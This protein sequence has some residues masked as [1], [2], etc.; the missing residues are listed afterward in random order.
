MAF[1]VQHL[2]RKGDPTGHCT[3]WSKAWNVSKEPYVGTDLSTLHLFALMTQQ[4]MAASPPPPPTLLCYSAGGLTL[5]QEFSIQGCGCL[6]GRCL[7]SDE[8]QD[9]QRW[10]L[11][12]LDMPSCPVLGSHCPGLKSWLSLPPTG[13]SALI[14]T[15][16]FTLSACWDLLSDPGA[17]LGEDKV[18]R[19]LPGPHGPCPLATPPSFPEVS[20]LRG[21]SKETVR[22]VNV[23]WA[24]ILHKSQCSHH[25][26]RNNLYLEERDRSTFLA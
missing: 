13:F 3:S 14:K 15:P 7:W 9:T 25:F 11:S 23:L 16:G 12:W 8:P 1:Q 21:I 4:E 22:P 6:A 17:Y 26:T 10:E 18:G 5:S 24:L 19:H 20:P 2:K